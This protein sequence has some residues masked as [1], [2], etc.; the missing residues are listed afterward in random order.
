MSGDRETGGEQKERKKEK[1][2]FESRML[3]KKKGFP[4]SIDLLSCPFPYDVCTRMSVFL[5]VHLCA[6]V[7]SSVCGGSCKGYDSVTVSERGWCVL[8]SV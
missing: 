6:S 4:K 1:K 2:V 8:V 5:G 7:R 3:G